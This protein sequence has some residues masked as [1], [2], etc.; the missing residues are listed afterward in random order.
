[1]S[2]FR[3]N[4]RLVCGLIGFL[5]VCV[6]ADSDRSL[7]Q[8]TPS[9]QEVRRKIEQNR[10]EIESR[11]R[12]LERNRSSS[13][14]RSSRSFRPSPSR[15]VDSTPSSS[16]L[17]SKYPEYDWTEGQQFAFSVAIQWSDG[18]YDHRVSGAPY[19][20]VRSVEGSRATLLVI[21]RFRHAVKKPGETEYRTLKS[22]DYWTPTIQTI[23]KR[24]IED[25][26]NKEAGDMR[27][28]FLMTEFVNLPLVLTPSLP[29]VFDRKTG[30]TE[31]AVIS[32]TANGATLWEGFTS[33]RGAGKVSRYREAKPFGGSVQIEEDEG[34]DHGDVQIA[35][36]ATT[37]LDSS[38]GLVR[39]VSGR[40]SMK[41]GN[42]ST[43]ASISV[44][45]LS[46]SPLNAAKKAAFENLDHLPSSLVPRK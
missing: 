16:A 41:T 15:S 10:R 13:F 40:Y 45:R 19:Y 44:R 3:Q 46:G 7:A 8:T 17:R 26:G 43:V 4:R 24:S 1:M 36:K 2:T 21:G 30:R 22:W 32:R 42:E 23:G 11:R 33:S 29:T 12:E 37:L 27:L 38:T 25:Y 20:H 9:S 39:S 6:V 31:S 35:Y 18:Q 14:S 28:P 5:T 34:L